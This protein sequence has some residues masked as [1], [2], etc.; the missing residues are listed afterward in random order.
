MKNFKYILIIFT[1]VFTSCK[2][3]V[4]DR[5]LE[6]KKSY[7]PSATK[8][9][10]SSPDFNWKTTVDYE[11]E[12]NPHNKGVIVVSDTE[13]NVVYRALV[14][15]NAKHIAKITVDA[16]IK[17][18]IVFYNGNSEIIEIVKNG[19]YKSKLI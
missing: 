9:V 4:I 14:Q 16:N 10:I 8:D 19:Y 2:K 12:I 1:L 6:L 3:D 7:K 15:P 18:L 11:L 5:Y 13:G 17:S